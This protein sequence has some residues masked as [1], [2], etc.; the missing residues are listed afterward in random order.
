MNR[1]NARFRRTAAACGHSCIRLS[2]IR[3]GATH[4]RMRRALI[5]LATAVLVSFGA[6]LRAGDDLPQAAPEE[7]GMSA[8]RLQ[9]IG[10]I[11]QGYVDRG[12]L[13]GTVT[14]VARKGKVVYYEANG[15]R[16]VEE[17]SSMTTD[18]I[19]RIASMTKPIASVALMMLFE[20]GRFKLDDPV[21]KWIPQYADQQVA[22]KA[23]S[24]ERVA[25]PFKLV[26]AEREI[27]IRHLLTHTAGLA[28]SYRGMT[29]ELLREAAQNGDSPPRT[30]EE[31]L[32]RTARVP[33]NFQPGAEWEYGG[34]TNVVGV[35]VEKMSGL[36][37]DAFFRVRIFEPLG[38]H[39]THF[40][41]PESKV[42]RQAAL[43]RPGE[44]GKI[45]LARAP[46]FREPSSYFSGA[47]GLA[48][49]AADYFRFHQMV[50]NGGEL[51]GVRLLSPKTIN[52]M[53]TNQI[54]DIEVWLKG[55]GYGFGLGYSVLL[56][57]G[58]ASEPL[59]PGSFGWG[60]AFCTYFFVDPVE[61]MIGILMTQVRPYTHLDVR[62][63]LSV[64]A[65]QAIVQ[66]NS[67]APSKILGYQPRR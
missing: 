44:D 5:A 28:N 46:A 26:A 49:T 35:L 43:Y 34:A 54:G 31:M 64:L 14:L 56:D 33:L 18:T 42:E 20:E 47:G 65:T 17:G 25:A 45:V 27:T 40:N 6:Q 29:R 1:P 63:Q 9:R 37:L 30:I 12:E 53:I 2:S 36:T 3:R 39:D 8:E 21:S 51:N 50:L 19:F 22:I 15:Y 67:A 38:M 10:P 41:I 62:H 13:A 24:G 55:P 32:L 23:P 59:S 58:K 57:P 16:Y 4:R 52:L 66:S 61:E 7:V 11:M 48:S 60:G